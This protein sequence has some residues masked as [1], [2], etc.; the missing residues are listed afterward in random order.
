MLFGAVEVESIAE[1]MLAG[2]AL[3]AIASFLAVITAKLKIPLTLILVL[4][5]F[6]AGELARSNGIDLPVEGETFHDVLLFVFLPVLLFEAALTLPVRVF[7]REIV[8]ILTLAIVAM[9]VAAGLTALFVHVSLGISIASALVF[10]ALISATDPV[11]VTATF[12]ELGVPP[13]LLVL[14]EGESLFNDGFAIV[15]FSIV[16]GSALGT[17]EVGVLS[18]LA[19]FIVVFAGGAALGGL[20]GLG[21]AEIAARL[22]R[23]PS[24]ALT[25]A[26]AYG[27]F[28]LGEEVLG[29]SGAIAAVSA[30]IVMAAFSRTLIPTE[31]SETWH[32]VWEAL[33]FI[34]N[35]LLFLLIG[36]VIEADLITENLNEIGVGVAAVLIT[37][38]LAILP[39]TRPVN[40]LAGIPAVGIRNEAVLVWGGLRGGVALALALAIPESLAEQEKFVAMTAGVVLAT[41]ILNATTIRALI[42]RLGLD[43]PDQLERFV[44]AAARFD[45]ARAARAQVHDAFEDREV[46]SRLT[47]VERAAADEIARLELSA[48]DLHQALLRRGLAVEQASLQEMVDEGLVPQ[49][50]G[51]V[52]L[53]NLEDQLDELSMGRVSS[54][55]LFET[56]RPER[57]I[58]EVARRIHMGRL[59]VDKWVELAYRD[60]QA[61]I[62]ATSD[63]IE[64]IRT[65]A[66]CPGVAAEATERTVAEFD[67]WRIA[68]RRNLDRLVAEAPAP[69]LAAAHRHYAADLARL[70]SRQEL[71]HLAS[72]G[73]VSIVA[74]DLASELIIEHL[75]ACERERV[76]I[77]VDEDE[78]L[79][80]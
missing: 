22:G 52:A 3:L 18:G 30:G 12:R 79:G 17:E 34:A 26:V 9:A 67:A 37:R 38:P 78:D 76:S 43:K 74:V 77:A 51:R 31:I 36:V 16:L 11:S 75:E 68:A 27:S 73:L 62:K 64:A 2:A 32:E 42:E 13:R 10:G 35:G 59:T 24:V 80:T 66:V 70:T 72:M 56:T 21:T 6:A 7:A 8:P 19:E 1:V 55:G 25:I 63:A 49:W 5:G 40:K 47:E 54:R 71:R 33:A 61:R 15:L 44:A 28:A 48:A 60:L 29:V 41:L 20:L 4:V 65:L 39:I 23:M 57:L 69:A 46:E 45:G 14:V 58:Y 53:G 50:H